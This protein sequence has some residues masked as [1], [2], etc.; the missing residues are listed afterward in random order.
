MRP[1]QYREAGKG[2]V[3]V[4]SEYERLTCFGDSCSLL[5]T[6]SADELRP[7]LASY[8]PS[9]VVPFKTRPGYLVQTVNSSF[10]YSSKDFFELVSSSTRQLFTIWE[11][12]VP[13]QFDPARRVTPAQVPW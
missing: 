8:Y 4:K 2:L 6:S 13:V 12:L 1:I 3:R 5:N 10:S 11:V 7:I 9:Q